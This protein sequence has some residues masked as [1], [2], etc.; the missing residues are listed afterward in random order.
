[1][2]EYVGKVCPYCKTPL[3]EDDEVVVCSVCDMPHHKECWIENEGCTTFGCLGTIKSADGAASQSPAP[4]AQA[5]GSSEV[6]ERV[7]CTRCGTENRMSSA[8]CYRCGTPL[9][10]HFAPPG[11]AQGQNAAGGTY[12]GYVPAAN[13][14][15]QFGTT[16]IDPE[17]RLYVREASEYYIPKF[18]EMKLLGKKAS[19]NWSA[20][21][22]TPYW[23]MYRK[24][25][26]YGAVAFW[27]AL[28]L[29]SLGVFG[30]LLAMAGYVAVGFFGNYFYMQKIEKDIAQGKSVDEIY[31]PSYIAQVGGVS[32]IA[33]IALL[34]GHVMVT[35]ILTN[36]I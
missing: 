36:I 10:S 24:M 31:K 3:K 13:Y 8:F 21:L 16:N 33:P 17:T 20:F 32:Q 22:V 28:F 23:L 14:Q 6:Q 34:V 35:T 15:G 9:R 12:G 11:P 25:Y 7:F 27:A 29:S 4:A 18:A 26:E 30:A 19:W 2:N 1:M 5:D